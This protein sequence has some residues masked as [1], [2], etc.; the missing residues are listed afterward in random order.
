VVFQR[1]T[2]RPGWQSSVRGKQCEGKAKKSGGDDLLGLPANPSPIG[3]DSGKA[4]TR[5]QKVEDVLAYHIKQ[6]NLG[7]N[8]CQ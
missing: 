8:L 7:Y 5:L 4:A 6:C 2:W 3:S 1:P